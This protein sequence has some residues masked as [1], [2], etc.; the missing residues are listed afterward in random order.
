[1]R[2]GRPLAVLALIGVLAV[3]W[4]AIAPAEERPVADPAR[5]AAARE[6][7]AATGSAR[8]FEAVMPM[9][10]AQ[11]EPLFLQMAPGKEQE[12][13]DVLA[14]TQDRF[15]KRKTELLEEIAQLYSEKMSTEDMQSLAK[16]FSD[17]AGA[18]FIQ[19]QPDLVQGSMQIGQRWGEQ[20]GKEL[21]AEVRQELQ[22][23]G[24]KI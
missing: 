20:I 9:L 1:M 10:M 18:R 24:I 17:G 14:L 19:M 12:V 16:F 13:K 7:M 4:T 22:K 3:G 11:M 8:Q 2:A 5:I 23:R 6:L 21:E 15:S